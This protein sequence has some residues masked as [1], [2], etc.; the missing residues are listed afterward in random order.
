[1][2]GSVLTLARTA[3]AKEKGTFYLVELQTGLGERAYDVGAPALTYG[4]SVGT[5]FKLK[6]LPVRWYVL[7]TIASRGDSISGDFSGMPYRVDR[8]DL[9]VFLAQRLVLP[10]H[11]NVR[12][13]VEGGVGQRYVNQTVTRADVGTIRDGS[14]HLL[15][16]FAG[17]V[18]ARVSR[19]FSIGLRGEISPLAGGGHLAESIT[20]LRT[21]PNRLSLVGQLGV[22]F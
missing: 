8:R 6:V 20:D 12:V 11:R 4:L 15:V 17:G 2:C 22:H 16:I 19:T 7:G 21:T 10:V 18:Q 1:L 9:D 5:T 3:E 13:F 14:H